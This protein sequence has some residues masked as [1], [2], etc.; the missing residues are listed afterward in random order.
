M[1]ATAAGPAA[2]GADLT[3]AAILSG[4]VPPPKGAAALYGA[5]LD[6]FQ[7]TREVGELAAALAVP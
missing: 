5:L 1:V 3:P 4:K 6:A 2:G 7:D